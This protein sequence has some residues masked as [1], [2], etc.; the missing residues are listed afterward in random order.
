MYEMTFNP[1]ISEI[2]IHGNVKVTA[3]MDYLQHIA[4]KHADQLGVGHHQIFHKGLTWLLLR[5]TAEIT[6][7]PQFDESLRVITWVAESESPKYTIRDFEIMDEENNII[8]KATTSWLLFNYRKRQPI[9]FMDIWPDFKAVER[10]ALDYDFPGLQLPENIETQKSLKVRLQD[11]DIQQHVNHISHINWIIE[12]MPEK[13]VKKYELEKLEISYKE[14]GFYE[15]DILIE[16]EI[17]KEKDNT[18]QAI[19][20]IVKNKKRQLV[21]KA[22][23][24]WKMQK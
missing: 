23:T 12:G 3:L 16:T 7:Y 19:H 2:D 20:Q 10:R 5:Y 14:Q 21:S 13:I 11:L 4:Y 15:D 17:L 18:I 22:V 8:C 24:Q 1:R 9:N 6:R